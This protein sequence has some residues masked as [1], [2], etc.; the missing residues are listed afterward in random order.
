MGNY[1]CI[2]ESAADNGWKD[3]KFGGG[4]SGSLVIDQ[5]GQAIGLYWGGLEPP[6]GEYT[7]AL[8]V[9]LINYDNRIPN[10]SYHAFDDFI[11]EKWK[12]PAF[13]K[14]GL[15]IWIVVSLTIVLIVLIIIV[16]LTRNSKRK[17][18]LSKIDI[19]L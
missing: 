19:S 15:I 13:S 8:C 6:T 2:S 17:K 3:Y 9:E 4:A 5:Y 11:H 16:V 18:M 1:A 10:E 12:N 7:P 14:M